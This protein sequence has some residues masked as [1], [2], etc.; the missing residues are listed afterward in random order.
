VRSAWALPL[1]YILVK[2]F[3]LVY[4]VEDDLITAKITEVHLRQHGA[5]GRVQRYPN[6]QPA[7]EALLRSSAQ[8]AP[9]PDL[10]LLDLNMPVMDGWEFLDALAKQSWQQHL[11]VCVLTSSIQPDDQA[12]ADKYAAVKGYFS[13]PV[14]T[15]LLNAII[16]LVSGSNGCVRNEG[17]FPD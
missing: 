8:Q 13:K 6:G 7:L 17:H 4:V 3:D 16:Q 2:S 5:F 1:K 15:D 10:I 11:Q 12:K 9:L 14:S